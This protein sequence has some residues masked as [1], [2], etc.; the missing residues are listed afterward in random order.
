MLTRTIFGY[1]ESPGM[2]EKLR[3]IFEWM[4]EQKELKVSERI[5]GIG[6]WVE[7]QKKTALEDEKKRG[8]EDA[9]RLSARLSLR[10]QFIIMIITVI[11]GN[12]GVIVAVLYSLTQVAEK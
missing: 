1:A 6:D 5:K 11:L 9:A 2:E 4:E 10:N 7:T 8:Q 3:K 12:I